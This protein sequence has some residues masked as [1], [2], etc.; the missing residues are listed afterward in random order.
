MRTVYFIIHMFSIITTRRL[1][2]AKL[3]LRNTQL[4]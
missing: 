3:N 1:D 4:N 2:E